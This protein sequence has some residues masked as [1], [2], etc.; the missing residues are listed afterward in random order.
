MR[1]YRQNSL[2][3]IQLFSMKFVSFCSDALLPRLTLKMDD[4]FLPSYFQSC[5]CALQSLSGCCDSTSRGYVLP[6]QM[7]QKWRQKIEGILKHLEAYEI[8]IAVMDQ[9]RD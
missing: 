8:V 1:L 7:P 9:E 6:S 5:C 4:S 3:L 2:E